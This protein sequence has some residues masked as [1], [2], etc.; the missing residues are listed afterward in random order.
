LADG[1]SLYPDEIG[2]LNSHVQIKLLRVLEIF[3]TPNGSKFNAAKM[4]G[5][6]TRKIEYKIK[7][8]SKKWRF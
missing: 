2:E 8:W 3:Q 4:P 5:V 7:E 1:G 6:S